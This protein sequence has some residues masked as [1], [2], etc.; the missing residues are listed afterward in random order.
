MILYKEQM[1]TLLVT[2]SR[3]AKTKAAKIQEVQEQTALQQQTSMT[4]MKDKYETKITDLLKTVA[5]L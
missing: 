3:E 1:N 4:A 5:E 2:K